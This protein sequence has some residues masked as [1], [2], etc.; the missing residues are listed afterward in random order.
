LFA[1]AVDDKEFAVVI[2]GRGD[3][4]GLGGVDPRGLI[5]LQFFAIGW[6][7]RERVN[8]AGLEADD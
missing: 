6:V 8:A 1:G 4:A 3:V 7:E 5:V 2:A